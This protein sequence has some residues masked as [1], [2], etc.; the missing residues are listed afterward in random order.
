MREPTE[1]YDAD[2]QLSSQL[3]LLLGEM[4]TSLRTPLPS[5]AT[6][7]LMPILRRALCGEAKAAAV[8]AA[9]QAAFDMLCMHCTPS[10]TLL[11]SERRLQ[12]E[13]LLGAMGR[14]DRWL[15]DAASALSAVATSLGPA[16]TSELLRGAVFAENARVRA[17]VAE[18]AC[19]VPT[20]AAAAAAAADDDDAG[21]EQPSADLTALRWLLRFDDDVDTSAAGEAAWSAFA[22]GD[23]A[24]HVEV[25]GELL[26]LLADEQLRVRQQVARAL[27]AAEVSLPSIF[28]V[29]KRHVPPPPPSD[30]HMARM[31]AAENGEVEDEWR[32]RQGVGLTLAALA[33][34]L[35][36]REQLPV[37]FAFLKRALGD[38][39]EVV[40]QQMV[41][42]G[43]EI[44]ERQPQV[45]DMVAMLTPMFE[46]FLAEPATTEVHDRIR[47]GVV[48]YMASLAK[49]IPADDP[50]IAQ[51]VT[52]LM[53]ALGT[54]SEAVQ[55]TISQ[56]L[57]SLVGKA[58][59][60]PNASQYLADL[61]DTLTKSPSYAERRGAAFGLAGVVKGLGI[62]SLKQHGVMTALQAIVESKAKGEQESNA[63]EGALQAFE[64][65]CESLGRLFEP[66]IITILP[67][68][69]ACVADGSGSVR[70]A[71]VSAS[72]KIMSQLSAQGVKMVLPS[73]L[74]ALDEEK[75]RTKHA[76][77][78]LLGS[79]AYCAPK[80]LS[81]TLPQVVPALT[82]VLTHSHP[83]V[84][85]GANSALASVGAVI[86]NPEI[87]LLVPTLLKALSEP[88]THTSAALGALA[89]CQF[90]HCVDPPSLSLIVPVLHRGLRE[91]A[92]Q[93]KR[94]TSHITG[95]MCSLLADRKDIVPY[96]PLLLPELRAVLHDPIPEVRSTGAKA[97]GRLCA[98]LGEEHFPDLL[99]WL[100]NSLSKDGSTVE[101]AGAA[102]GLSEV[103]SALGDAKFAEI[104]PTLLEGCAAAEAQAREGFYTMWIHLPTVL[105]KRF[106]PF[107]EEVLPIVL[108]G[109]ADDNSAVR[110]TAMRGAQAMI[111]IYL[112][113]AAGL[114]LPPLQAGLSDTN[115]RIRE[116]SADLLGTL[117]GRMTQGE[118]VEVV[119]EGKETPAD[120]PLATVPV[121]QQ[122]ALLAAIYISRNDVH[123]GVR[124]ASSGVWK[125]LV[126]NAPR[127]LR[128]ILAALTEQLLL[129]LS[130]DDEDQQQA[131]AQALG[132]LVTKLSERVLPKLLPT[133]QAGLSTDDPARRRGVCLG[134]T[135]VMAAAGKE[136]V[137]TFLPKLIPAVRM[138][139]CDEDERVRE[140]AAPAFSQL[141]RLIGVQAIHEI[142]PAL[143]QLLRSTDPETVVKGQY[144][145]REV[146]GQR[147][148][149]VVPYLLPKLTAA[150][151]KLAH[152]RA[153]GAVAEVAGAALHTHLDALLPALFRETYVEMAL[154]PE[155]HEADPELRDALI[156]AASAVALAVE[157]DGLHYLYQ[158]LR[159]GTAAKAEPHVRVAAAALIE[160]V[161]KSCPYD[162]SM[163]HAGL[164]GALIGM[165]HAEEPPVLRAALS[166]LDALTKS[167]PK[168]RHALLVTCMRTSLEEVSVEYRTAQLA[169][170]VPHDE[171]SLL[172][173][174]C[175][176][177]GLS[178]LVAVY[179][180]GL[181][182]GTP[183]LREQSAS[184]LGEAVGVTSAAALK[185]FVIQ[186]TG[187]LIRI[188]GDRFPWQVKAAILQTLTLLIAKG[189]ILLKPFVP[190]L[191]TTFV[192]ALSDPTK[193]VRTRGSTALTRL[194][195]LAT[196]VEPLASELQTS[197]A[198]ADSGVQ[199]ALL[200]AL[201][202]LLREVTKPLS[203]PLVA[204]IQASAIE[205]L[206][207]EDDEVS[208]AAA[209]LMRTRTCTRTHTR[210][211]TR[212]HAHA[213]ARTPRGH[214]LCDDWHNL[215]IR[216]LWMETTAPFTTSF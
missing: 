171:P 12:V 48:F 159:S 26:P 40:A 34:T 19:H 201:A 162:L 175:E 149:A 81:A 57:A 215:L 158:E 181:M 10:L 209:T 184:A 89:H 60:K 163:H 21:A 11:Q 109:L 195:S 29:Y 74:R 5:S 108:E 113:A 51:V 116:S 150:P 178:S 154:A 88:A 9:H 92:A 156:G 165:F 118:A 78:E 42:A 179:L 111:A 36:A 86:K 196:R 104:L 96:L 103:L 31:L 73:L 138:G 126:T 105:G 168:E 56:S 204:K 115:Y 172:P 208:L 140:A 4:A 166:A 192:K 37:V 17:A 97:L 136:N 45:E 63:R 213:H 25:E 14:G 145:L 207:A 39:H 177:A 185:P 119:E 8:Q 46:S 41:Q 142:V 173:A 35:R 199:A 180:Q 155:G 122:H 190:Q 54:P 58:A 210:T 152:A 49:H 43:R 98:G 71:A 87:A 50:K 13:L 170:G 94:K 102:Q 187:P 174:L 77:V 160:T 164:I 66:Y 18:A 27:A 182:T 114:L 44:I 110:D 80:Q 120:S 197:L 70:Y 212:A 194:I 205:L 32:P 84:K 127:T 52:R 130:T 200:C 16:S 75:W 176:K 128:V 112:E 148:Q 139:L 144:G 135:E 151:I 107:L 38:E 157:E 153:L 76:A 137:T 83:K 189:S 68:L 62:P 65:L 106:E 121:P 30:P 117:M 183:E 134:L 143:L 61:Q 67:L 198:T 167:V 133:L 141:Q 101:R 100:L 93:A 28:D 7:L 169:A 206:C 203:E 99:P 202:G 1:P 6:T 216:L 95:N 82:E 53:A 69:L 125:T 186:I 2:S 79:M 161:C 23:E 188:V 15:G 191:Q 131:A 123:P 211:H 55:R 193:L 33:P 146:M 214:L 129:G 24:A 59:V 3:G 22:A 64:C 91:R 47:Q 90:E 85:E 147:P 124:M 20:T 132:E 72:Q